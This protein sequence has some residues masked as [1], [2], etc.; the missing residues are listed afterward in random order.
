MYLHADT[1]YQPVPLESRPGSR[2]SI[3]D[4]PV[5]PIIPVA[6]TQGFEP[7]PPKGSKRKRRGK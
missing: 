6:E 4:A 1:E 3:I 5:D 2:R 7:A